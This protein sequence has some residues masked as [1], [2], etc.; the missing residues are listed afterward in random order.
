MPD[1]AFQGSNVRV[2]RLFRAMSQEEL[3]R[4]VV[5]SPSAIGQMEHGR[6]PSRLLGD[7]VALAL[8]FEP[9]FFY[10]PLEDEFTDKNCNFRRQASATEK[11]RKRVLARGTLFA[12]VVRW[13]QQHLALPR[14]NVPR[15]T[16]A[17]AEDI[18]RAAEQC[19]VLW[20]LG[21]DLPIKHMGRVLEH[22]GV[23]V[24]RLDA[25]SEKLDAFSRRGEDGGVTVAVLNTLR[26]SPSRTRFDL[27]HELG[28]LVMHADHRL[29]RKTREAEAHRFASAFLLPRPAFS[30][31]FWSGGGVDWGL[32]LELKLRWKVSLQAMLYRA[33]DLALIDALE[34][35]R[36]YKALS[37]RRWV[38]SEPEE[39]AP[40]RPELFRHA[41]AT[42][43]EKKGMEHS[44]IAKELH[45]A[46]KTF[47]DV[48]EYGPGDAAYAPPDDV[49]SLEVYAREKRKL[50]P[51]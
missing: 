13:L 22:A 21:T 25:E 42:V 16:V 33:Y 46:T 6:R 9:D 30:R 15:I 44:E 37:F 8:G 11:L 50:E 19:R 43:R 26:S 10:V 31:E 29:P 39:P 41:M 45:W 12:S 48:T 17:S 47:E 28:H 5:A 7:A 4:L 49:V 27:A 36:A 40:E 18:E 34:F 51:A 32:M 35:R 14:L 2:A 38:Q 1:L 24:T 20:G 23:M 3:A